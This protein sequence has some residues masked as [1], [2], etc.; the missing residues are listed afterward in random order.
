MVLGNPV[1]VSAPR[2]SEPDAGPVP[3][4]PRTHNDLPQNERKN[5]S[6]QTNVS[7]NAQK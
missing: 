3:R 7:K 5:M 1:R 2:N 6:K 4:S